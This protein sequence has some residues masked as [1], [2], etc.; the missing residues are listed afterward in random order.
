VEIEQ[1]EERD[2]AERRE[3]RERRENLYLLIYISKKQK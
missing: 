1:R 2:R 3:K